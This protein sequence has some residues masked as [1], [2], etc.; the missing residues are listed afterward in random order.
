MSREDPDPYRR[1]ES[2]RGIYRFE[3]TEP[4][5]SQLGCALLVIVIVVSWGLIWY[6]AELLY[7]TLG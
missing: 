2:D 3:R 1:Y 5:R 7:R 6:V 4:P